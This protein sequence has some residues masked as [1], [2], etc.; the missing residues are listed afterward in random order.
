VISYYNITDKFNNN[1][2][3]IYYHIFTKLSTMNIY[4]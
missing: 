1:D 4:S 2:A 3:R